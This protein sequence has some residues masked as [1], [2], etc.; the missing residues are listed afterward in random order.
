MSK[1]PYQLVH[2]LRCMTLYDESN[3]MEIDG[4]KTYREKVENEIDEEEQQQFRREAIKENQKMDQFNRHQKQ[5]LLDIIVHES[6]KNPG[7]HFADLGNLYSTLCRL[8]ELGMTDN[9]IHNFV[10]DIN[11]FE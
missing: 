2:E 6:I 7:I 11:V 8:Y 5:R 4:E 9:Q 1:L 3:N 10:Y